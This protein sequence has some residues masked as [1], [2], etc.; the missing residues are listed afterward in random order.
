MFLNRLAIKLIKFYQKNKSS[1]KRCRHI[2]TCSNY[3]LDCYE[4]FNFIKASFLTGYR[5]IRCNPLSRN[6][7]DPVPLTKEQKKLK[8]EYQKKASMIDKNIIDVFNKNNMLEDIIIYIWENT[9]FKEEDIY[10]YF[11]KLERILYLIKKREITLDYKKTYKYL[12]E[13]MLSDIYIHPS[14]YLEKN[15]SI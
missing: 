4:K 9:S 7:Y 5:I 10:L 8:K 15:K 1:Y 13:Y 6:I 14:N 3:G 2:P 12:N 11:A